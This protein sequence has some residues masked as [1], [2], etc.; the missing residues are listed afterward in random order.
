MVDVISDMLVKIKNAQMVGKPEVYIPFS[1]LKFEIGKVL[2]RE[3]FV[4]KVEK[5]KRKIR[6]GRSSPKSFIKIFLKPKEKGI[7]GIKRISK[8]SQRVYRGWRELK[9]PKVGRGI[10]ILTTS[11]GVLSHKEARRLKVGGEVICHVW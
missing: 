9:L 7:L 2:E 3:K 10:L 1:K 5:V 11:K 8:P 4:E 6:K